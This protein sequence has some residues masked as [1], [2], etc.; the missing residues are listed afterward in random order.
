[1]TSESR[2]KA[3]FSLVEI[4][5]AIAA[6]G[7]LA[8]VATV[9]VTGVPDAAR[10]KKLDQDVAIV[11][12]AID[13]YLVAGGDAAQ[14]SEENVINALKQRVAAQG[15]GDIVG[16]Q[17]PFLDP[18][19]TTTPTD[20]SW[21]ALY[22]TDPTPRFY[23]AQVT[24][25]VIFGRGPAMAVGGVAER[26]DEARTSWLWAYTDATAPGET[27]AFV[28]TAVDSGPASTTAPSVAVTLAAPLISPAG[29]TGNLWN[30]P[31]QATLTNP[32]PSGSSRVYYK[33]GAGNYTLYDDTPF[34]VDPGT[35]LSAVAVSLDPSRYY[36]SSVATATYTVQPLPLAV[37]INPPGSVTY[38]QAGGLMIGQAQLSPA[39]ATITLED[40][41]GGGS[42]NLLT[43]DSGD[44]KYIPAP[45]VSS[46]NF[47]VRYTTD[48]SDPLTSGTASSSGA[49]SGY[50]SPVSV[51]LGLAAWGTNASMTIRAAAVAANE[52]WFANSPIS[53]TSVSISKVNLD[54]PTM[55]PSNQVV[56]ASLTVAMTNPA[57]GPSATNAM[58]IRYTTNG[59]TPSENNSTI[60][61]AP[62]VV[63]S[64]SIDEQRTI[65]A[66]TF[67]G[68]TLT[69]WFN[70][71]TAVSRTYTGPTAAGQG[72]GV[73][74]LVGSATL[75]STFNGNVTIAY[76][77]NG[78][79]AN[80]T[81]NM[82]AVINGSLYVPGTPR[83]AQNTPYIPQWTLANDL[84]FS[85]RIRG[86][87]E[88]QS[89][90]PRVVDLTGPITPT[91]YVITFNNNSYISGKIF[92]RAER[93]TLT[94]LNVATF[95][96]KTSSVSLSLSGPAAAPLSATNVANV[97][98]NTESVGSVT[99]LPGTYGNMTA[100]NNAKFVLGNAAD[101][102]TPVTYSFD[103]LA[104][105]S[106][107]DLVIV[108]KV[109]LN[110]RNGFEINNL[111]VLG[112]VERPDWLQINVWNG[113]VAANSGSSI[114]GRIYAPNNRVALNNGS[115]LVGS[116]SAKNM[117]LNSSGVV[118]SLPP[119]TTPS[120]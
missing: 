46:G 50:Y 77:T 56:V 25:G 89:P 55:G 61:S 39:T 38:A 37:R 83:I 41:S 95:P 59:A 40:T 33:V 29:L 52:G 100:N 24:T 53:E 54:P 34:N 64:F 66:A 20:F 26:P 93:Y 2:H 58:I 27:A 4:L 79:V 9:T 23:V 5:V 111:S 30:F 113:D 70:P 75:N 36:N 28:P 110:I 13:A 12:N 65:T 76:P 21:S 48:G 87:V 97:T 120:G 116:V 47:N 92:R 22:T 118:F 62:V 43:D 88:G 117:E 99:L 15:G 85:N 105:N 71:S 101:P 114:Y 6:L 90:S 69:N 31:L 108:G 18:T 49:F 51:S 45:Y 94:P 115:V 63:T 10:K 109:I 82:N 98:L 17:G 67:P 44:D 16:P 91:N 119:P 42:D 73:G 35:T 107:A 32:N 57:T 86:I 80:I 96:V 81:Y 3:A 8:T 74:A 102:E 112:K 84:Q 68:A 1:M 103:R 19:V 104:L 78:V 7:I 11:N 72:V 106:G 14:L 60:Y